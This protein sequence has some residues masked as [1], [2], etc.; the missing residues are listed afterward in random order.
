V[1]RVDLIVLLIGFA[2]TVSADMPSWFP[3]WQEPGY[4]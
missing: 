4:E 1:G 2:N 3:W